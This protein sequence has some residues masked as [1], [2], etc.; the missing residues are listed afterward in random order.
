MPSL[1][2]LL[3]G[4]IIYYTMPGRRPQGIAEVIEASALRGGR[5]SL[6]EGVGAAIA[7]AGSI[8][9]GASVGREGPAV[10]LGATLGA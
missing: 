4:V 1:G 5:M 10:H 2:G 3:I 8:G 9:V 7:S 6:R